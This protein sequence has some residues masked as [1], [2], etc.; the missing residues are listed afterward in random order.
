MKRMKRLAAFLLLA[1]MLANT[2][3]FYAFAAGGEMTLTVSTVSGTPGEEVTVTVD[4]SDNPGIASL[5]FDVNYDSMLTLVD[6]QFSEAFGN[7]VTTP[8]PYTNP[9]T[10][11][12]ISPFADTSA[13]GTLA[14]LTF[15]ISE[16][17]ADEYEA[18]VSIT[19]KDND[20]YNTQKELVKT[21]A[22]NGKVCVF[23]GI[24]GDVNGD[25]A[26]NTKDAVL[27]FRYVAGWDVTVDPLAVDCNGDGIVDTRDAIELFR[28]T[29]DWPDIKLYYA[30]MCAHDLEYVEANEAT[31]TEDGNVAHWHCSACNGNYSDAKGKEVLNAVIVDAIGH[32]MQY[33]AE[34][35]PTCTESGNVE[36]WHCAN[37][38]LN[39][40]DEDGDTVIG[41]TSISATG[42]D[43]TKFSEQSATCTES[44]NVTYWFCETCEKNFKDEDATE[45]IGDVT[46]SASGHKLSFVEAKEATHISD[47]NVAYWYCIACKCCFTDDSASTEIADVVIPATGHGEMLE[48]IEAKESTVYEKGNEEY[49]YCPECDKYYSDAETENELVGGKPERDLTPYYTVTFFDEFNWAE[50]HPV[51]FPQ[52]KNLNLNTQLPPDYSGYEFKGWYTSTTYADS[53][54]IDAVEAGNTKDYLVFAK[55]EAEVYTITY[56]HAPINSNLTTYTVKNSFKLAAPKWEGLIFSHWTDDNDNIIT[57]IKEGTTGNLELEAHWISPQNYSVASTKNAPVIVI[58]PDDEEN[59]MELYYLV[60]EVG[61]VYNV[62]LDKIWDT[63]KYNANETYDEEHKKIV[64]VGEETAKTINHAITSSYVRSELFSESVEWMT[65][66]SKSKNQSFKL[67]PEVEAK[68]VKAKAFEYENGKETIE[69]EGLTEYDGHET[70]TSYGG[71]VSDEISSTTLYHYDVTTERSRRLSLSPDTSPAGSYTLAWAGDFRI[72]AIVTYNPHTEDY[73][74]N[75]YSISLKTYSTTFYDVLPEYN[76]DVDI[77]VKNTLDYKIPLETAK[78]DIIEAS[79]YVEYDA[80]GGE[81]EKMP[82][83]VGASDGSLTLLPNTYTKTGYTFAGWEYMIDTSVSFYED[84]ATITNPCESGATLTLKAK[85]TPNTYIVNYDANGGSGATISSSDYVYD[86]EKDL[87]KNTYYRTGYDFIG[88]STEADAKTPTYVDG[89][90]VKNLTNELNGTVTLY[91]VWKAHS[92][93]VVYDK[94]GGSG[95][96][97]PSEFTY[98]NETK[99]NPSGFSRSSY[100]F[101]GWSQDSAA[102]VPEYKVNA[103][104]SFSDIGNALYSGNGNTVTLYA[105]WIKTEAVVGYYSREIQINDNT[106]SD[107]FYPSLDRSALLLNGYTQLKLEIQINGKGEWGVQA[108]DE[109]YFIV[110]SHEDKEVFRKEWGHDDGF[111]AAK[112]ERRYVDATISLNDVQTDGSFWI[113]YGNNKSSD[114]YKLGTVEIII[115]AQ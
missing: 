84:G 17:A 80:N 24:P 3:P 45:E 57:E 60:Y 5:V 71:D 48:H 12:L 111:P 55:M 25:K 94:N 78:S 106:H 108:Y 90:L 87:S 27:L 20:I 19:C 4:V 1:V 31:C 43:L 99:L 104:N 40:A 103:D 29:A 64:N 39:F 53:T 62:L 33:N 112:W 28:Y 68:G 37:C 7:L 105:I 50:G 41:V 44:G 51:R 95:S 67:C 38:E 59:D 96:T 14:T 23:R 114:D 102:I 88:W 100:T 61:T 74:I 35:A 83:S 70:G 115:V 89:E 11:T 86:V 110:Y 72:F 113:K 82:I 77:I 107:T 92:Y 76:L 75:L 73:G 30:T 56:H 66:N 36:Y 98:D 34:K 21:K 8:T 63:Y 6:V 10:I 15:A 2:I 32:D 109:P 9:Q 79:F 101:L 93:T 42:H 16:S 58:K 91:A 22:V 26:V 47:G 97:D 13:N 49:W 46:V 52:N 69:T 18:E 54:K 65:S 81:G 85:W